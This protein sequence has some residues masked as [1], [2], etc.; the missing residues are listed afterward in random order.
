M[1]YQAKKN[2][3]LG[4]IIRITII[5]KSVACALREIVGIIDSILEIDSDSEV[6]DEDLEKVTRPSLFT[7]RIGLFAGKSHNQMVLH[8]VIH[9]VALSKLINNDRPASF[10]TRLKIINTSIFL[11]FSNIYFYYQSIS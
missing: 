8:H 1:R 2:N 3:E 4:G 11:I 7:E 5:N 6:L 10:T 9:C